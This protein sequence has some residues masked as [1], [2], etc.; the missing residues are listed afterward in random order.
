MVVFRFLGV[1]LFSLYFSKVWVAEYEGS[2][3]YDTDL[4]GYVSEKDWFAIEGAE[5]KESILRDFVKQEV[6]FGEAKKLGLQHNPKTN[7]KLENRFHSLVVNEYYMREFLGSLVPKDGLYFCKKNLKNEVFVSHI[8]LPLDGESFDLAVQTKN[9]INQGE[10]FSGFAE[11][12]SIDPS[13]K[14]NKGVLGWVSIGQTVPEFQ[15]AA[16]NLCVGC[17]D[18]VKTDFGYHIIKVDS[19]RGSQYANL[20]VPEYNDWAFRF[21]TA[22]IKEDLPTAAAEHDSLLVEQHDVFISRKALEEVVLSLKKE[23]ES[24]GSRRDVDVLR[25]LGEFEGVVAKYGGNLLGVGW[26]VNKINE[27]LYQKNTF[28]ET[29]DQ[30]YN[31]FMRILIR[32]IVFSLGLESGVD[33]GHS[34]TKQFSSLE[35]DILYKAYIKNLIDLVPEPSSIEI[36]NYYNE[37]KG[38]AGSLATSSSSIRAILLQEKQEEAQSLFNERLDSLVKINFMWLSNNE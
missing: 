38:E 14:N 27:G 31:E 24:K 22:Y 30:I 3:F 29:V 17:V 18:I 25:V 5:K 13:A 6:A 33:R 20:S 21:A 11:N 4:F 1:F 26:F 35:K 32:D 23:K 15:S 28:Y 8:L 7:K 34:F 37:N 10:S 9:Q 12:L 16:F 2:L 19:L 36:E